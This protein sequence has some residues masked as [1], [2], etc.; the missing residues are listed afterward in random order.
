M[1][2]HQS[3]WRC[4]INLTNYLYLCHGSSCP[5]AAHRLTFPSP[6]PAPINLCL[7]RSLFTGLLHCEHSGNSSAP[8]L[9][10]A[11]LPVLFATQ[12]DFQPPPLASCC[13]LLPLSAPVSLPHYF[14]P[15]PR[16]SPHLLPFTVLQT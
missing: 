6:V 3:T 9:L 11:R 8:F 4:P 5:S 14:R 15:K 10:P 1:M 13:Q 7:C 12:P 16:K 2:C